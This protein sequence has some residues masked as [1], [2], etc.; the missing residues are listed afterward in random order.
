MPGTTNSLCG[1]SV[2]SY[3]RCGSHNALYDTQTH[4]TSTR[5]PQKTSLSSAMFSNSARASTAGLRPLGALRT[6]SRSWSLRT[7]FAV[8]L[9]TSAPLPRERSRA[10]PESPDRHHECSTPMRSWLSPTLQ[11]GRELIERLQ[12]RHPETRSRHCTAVAY[13]GPDPPP[14]C[15][16]RPRWSRL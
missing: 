6:L 5:E 12:S 11:P 15:K 4:Q 2:N 3:Q 7:R 9:G 16:R 1:P 8:D 14:S 10:A 13:I